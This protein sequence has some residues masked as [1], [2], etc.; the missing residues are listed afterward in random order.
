MLDA[1]RFVAGTVARKELIEGLSHFRIKNG[2]VQAYNGEVSSASRIGLNLGVMPHAIKMIDAVKACGDDTIGLSITAAGRLSV[3]AGK[4]KCFVPCLPED[5][6]ANQIFPA[7]EGT[8]V[9]LLPAFI[10]ALRELAPL[11][12][13]DGSRPWACGVMVETNSAYATNNIL[14]AQKWH[15]MRLPYRVTIPADAV[16]EIVRMKEAPTG[17]QMTQDSVT[18]HY[19]N[20]RWVRTQLLMDQ[21]PEQLP[22]VL[23]MQPN[24]QPQPIPAGFFDA[25]KTLEKFVG[26]DSRIIFGD[27]LLRTSTTDGDGA[28]VGVDGIRAGP[29]FHIKALQLLKGHADVIDFTAYPRPCVFYGKDLRGVVAGL[30]AK[31]E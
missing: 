9:E 15:G 26:D 1:L 30:S 24:D 12:S 11:M 7:P 28:T 21:F 13:D 18:L 14:V 16:R 10:T 5:H 6:A 20:D 19:G 23:D 27:N 29:Q 17:M 2:W 25:L 4:F 3:A 22:K 8:H 31:G